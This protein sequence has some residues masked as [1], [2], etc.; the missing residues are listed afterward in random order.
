[1]DI[2]QH[3]EAMHLHG[4]TTAIGTNLANLVPLFTFA[5]TNVHS[6]VLATPLEQY[7]D[8]YIGYDPEWEDKTINKLLWRGST[9][10]AEF[11]KDVEWKL[12]QRARLHFLGHETQGKKHVLWADKRESRM[13]V[14]DFEIADL[15]REYMDVSFSGHPVQCDDE[16]C[17]LMDRII[18]FAPTMGLDDSY[19][20]KF[21]MDVDGNGWSG[22]FHRL[23]ST[24]SIVLKSTVRSILP[25]NY[26]MAEGI[27][28]QIFPEW[29]S[30]RIMPWVQ[31]V[32]RESRSSTFFTDF[33]FLSYVPIKVDYSDLYD[34]MT[35]FIG[36]PDGRGS[37]DDLA[38]KLAA[39]G[40][41][42]AR[43][44]WRKEDMASYMFRLI[45][46]MFSSLHGVRRRADYSTCTQN[47]LALR[48]VV[49]RKT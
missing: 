23:M 7:S 48:T 47:G 29:Y 6:D 37:H 9:T 15:N 2:C 20:Y 18:E 13:R 8:T 39:Q 12:S 19:Q 41:E 25:L 42:Y 35:F 10:G 38:A 4:F 3:P 27:H 11:R 24:K 40:K 36:T 31:C 45:L 1:M 5:K 28:L 44:M 30:E 14:S 17:A 49:V 21:L 16:T 32:L 46:G 43:T 33:L 34:V 26:D 22:R